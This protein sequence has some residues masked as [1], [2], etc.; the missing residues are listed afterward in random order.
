M[1]H[2]SNVEWACW[3]ALA[4]FLVWLVILWLQGSR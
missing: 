3:A 1:P 2:W 4:A